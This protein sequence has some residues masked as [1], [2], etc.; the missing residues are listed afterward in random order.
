MNILITGANSGLG[1]HLVTKFKSKGHNIL[2]HNGSKHYNLTNEKELLKL[3]EDAKKFKV[4]VLI[5]NAA[6]NCPGVNL[7]SYTADK[8][9]DMIGV[10]LTAPILLTYHLLPQLTNIININSIVGLEVKSLRTLYSATKWGLRGFAQ[11]LKAENNH[12]SVLDVYPTNIKTTPDKLNAMDVDFVVSSI[13]N[14]FVNKEKELILDG[15][16]M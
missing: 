5:N 11:S 16:K 1:K 10:N 15:R 14:A 4:N 7:G 2:E 13:Y 8:I 3:I 9:N 12:L 6:I